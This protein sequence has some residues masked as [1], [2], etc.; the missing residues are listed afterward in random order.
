MR[1]LLLRLLEECCY[2]VFLRQLLI[3]LESV[4]VKLLQ[5]LNVG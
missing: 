3:V 5:F 1:A 2:L 4:A